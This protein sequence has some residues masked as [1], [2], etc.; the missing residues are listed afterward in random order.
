[1]K[2][3]EDVSNVLSCKLVE[4]KNL[5]KSAPGKRCADAAQNAAIPSGIARLCNAAWCRFPMDLFNEFA[6][7][8]TDMVASVKR[9]AD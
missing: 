3:P 8:D 6:I 4:E 5:S 7:Q 2:Q 9:G 1:M